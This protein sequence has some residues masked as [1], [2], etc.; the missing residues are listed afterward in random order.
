M[1]DK[2][3]SGFVAETTVGRASTVTLSFDEITALVDSNATRDTAGATQLSLTQSTSVIATSRE[4][5]D[6]SLSRDE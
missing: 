5:S 2:V 6:V 1:A 4:S 3:L